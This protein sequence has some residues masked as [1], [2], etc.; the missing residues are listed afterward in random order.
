MEIRL[1]IRLPTFPAPDFLTAWAIRVRPSVLFTLLGCI[2]LLTLVIGTPGF[3]DK[4]LVYMIAGCTYVRLIIFTLYSLSPTL[5]QAIHQ[6]LSISSRSACILFFFAVD[7][8]LGVRIVSGTS[9]TLL[10]SLSGSPT[11]LFYTSFQQGARAASFMAVVHLFVTVG[12]AWVE[13]LCKLKLWAVFYWCMLFLF[14][15]VWGIVFAASPS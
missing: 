4:S 3:P 2:W 9:N 13:P 8:C 10:A 14:D 6:R 1:H 11:N 15:V 5:K 12:F 7:I